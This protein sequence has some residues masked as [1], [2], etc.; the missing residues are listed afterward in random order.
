[1]NHIIWYFDITIWV[2]DG[3]FLLRNWRI[4]KFRKKML[5]GISTKL[6]YDIDQ[7]KNVED[8]KRNGTLIDDTYD[9]Y[10]SVRLFPIYLQFWRP[11]KSFYI[12]PL[13][14]TVEEINLRNL[15]K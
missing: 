10:R 3:I 4:S 8:F 7:M 13:L 12:H 9:A 5:N 11:V 14:P 2:G 15:G 6:D 1:M